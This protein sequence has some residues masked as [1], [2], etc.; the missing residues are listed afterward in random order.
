MQILPISV[1][2]EAIWGD[3]ANVNFYR[4]FTW[5]WVICG[6][7]ESNLRNEICGMKMIG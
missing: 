6:D 2:S 5:V 3:G 7:A 1:T 4:T